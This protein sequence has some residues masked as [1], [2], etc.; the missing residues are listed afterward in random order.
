MEQKK[1]GLENNP[2]FFE[3]LQFGID[4]VPYGHYN[5]NIK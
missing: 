4:K 5:K 1:C 3:L 2:H